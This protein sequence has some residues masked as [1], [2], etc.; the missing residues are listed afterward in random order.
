MDVSF[1]KVSYRVYKVIR[2]YKI[3]PVSKRLEGFNHSI[4]Y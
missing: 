2:R 3:I 1:F 4:I